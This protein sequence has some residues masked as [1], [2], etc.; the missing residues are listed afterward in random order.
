MCLVVQSAQMLVNERKLLLGA[1]RTQIYLWI[2]RLHREYGSEVIVS[3]LE[4]FYK[5]SLLVELR[6]FLVIYH[7][8]GFLLL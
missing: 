3:V 8:A 5:P 4:L 7:Y 2:C 6:A 1:N